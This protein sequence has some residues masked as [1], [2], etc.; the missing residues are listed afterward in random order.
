MMQKTWKITKNPG[1]WVLIGEY[2]V[3][4]IQWIPTLQSYDDFQKSLCPCAL[5]QSSLSIGR[6]NLIVSFAHTWHQ[7][8]R[9]VRPFHWSCQQSSPHQTQLINKNGILT[10]ISRHCPVDLP[11]LDPREAGLTDNQFLGSPLDERN[12][13]AKV[14]IGSRS[15]LFVNGRVYASVEIRE[16]RYWRHSDYTNHLGVIDVVGSTMNV[17]H[18]IINQQILL[19]S[20]CMTPSPGI[21]E[22][23]SRG[24]SCT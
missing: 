24:V 5:D 19:N 8:W 4:A 16:I 15:G 1:K 6:V 13:F 14:S 3:R 11:W 9:H 23:H 21:D 2:S 10:L 22:N 18:W 12:T 20:L 17:D 7:H